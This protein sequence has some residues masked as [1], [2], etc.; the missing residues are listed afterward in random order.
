MLQI[1]VL[2]SDLSTRYTRAWASPT[3]YQKVSQ[4]KLP[5][6]KLPCWR[7]KI[8]T[9]ILEHLWYLLTLLLVI[10]FMWVSFPH[11]TLQLLWK[12]HQQHTIANNTYKQK[13]TALW[14]RTDMPSQIIFT[15]AHPTGRQPPP[16]SSVLYRIIYKRRS[17]VAAQVLLGEKSGAYRVGPDSII[18][19]LPVTQWNSYGGSW[20]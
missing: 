15:T 19:S 16:L 14:H 17:V 4:T 13:Y 5:T 2:D 18:P 3:L 11:H 1:F 6:G 20:K 9:L 10:Y 8:P 12:G 7:G